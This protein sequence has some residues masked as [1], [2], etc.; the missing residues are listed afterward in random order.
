MPLQHDRKRKSAY[1]LAGLRKSCIFAAQNKSDHGR[2]KRKR[3]T[4]KLG[5]VLF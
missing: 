3:G 4:V 1:P 2:S 5:Q